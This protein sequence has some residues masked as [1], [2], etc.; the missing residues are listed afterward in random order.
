MLLLILHGNVYVTDSGNS[1]VEKFT[2]SGSFITQWG[3]KG[4]GHG[5]FNPGPV[6][7]A[8]DSFGNVYVTD[9]ESNRV[10]KFDSSGTYITQWASYGPYGVAVDSS[11]NVYVANYWNNQVQKFTGSGTF[12][13]Q[14]GSE[15][16]GP[17]Q[18]NDPVGVAVDSSGNVYVTDAENDGVQ[19]FDSSG[20]YITQW[21]SDGPV[22]VAVDSSGNVYVTDA[23]NNRVQKF[24]SYGRYLTQWGDYG[25]SNGK[26]HSP[27]GI[28]VDLSG[29]VYVADESNN[30][31]EKFGSASIISQDQVI[32]IIAISAGVL[33]FLILKYPTK[34]E[35][36]LKHNFAHISRKRRISKQQIKLVLAV[37]LIVTL[38]GAY[39]Y[40]L[41][42]TTRISALIAS[43]SRDEYFPGFVNVTIV[44]SGGHNLVVGIIDLSTGSYVSTLLLWS[45]VDSKCSSRT[46]AD[47]HGYWVAVCS[48]DSG[49]VS[50]QFEVSVPPLRYFSVHKTQWWRLKAIVSI[51]DE[52]FN[53]IRSST[54]ELAFTFRFCDLNSAL[55][56]CYQ[57]QHEGGN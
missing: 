5:Q 27:S 56:G 24:D 20:N 3:S 17:G 13:T 31:V 57:N 45:S 46:D 51:A 30:R 28:A 15:G 34:T 54:S 39:A 47:Y 14:W 33:V 6:G 41:R 9:A 32:L 12:I 53:P 35:K 22:G 23:D 36:R 49:T 52:N 2:G 26:F 29:N 11:G 43:V 21:S 10:Q 48:A 7:V 18:F 25:Y 19:K 44:Y 42:P 37:I 4:F 16:S 8:V 50:A 38:L 55:P 40:Q 1:R